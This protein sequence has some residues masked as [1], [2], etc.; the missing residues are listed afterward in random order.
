MLLIAGDADRPAGPYPD[1]L[2][3]L[4]SGL[5]SD[6]EFRHLGFAGHPEGHRAADSDALGRA[7]ETKLIYGRDTGSE[8]WLVSQFTF[9]AEPVIDWLTAL[10][11]TGYRVPVRIG[12]AGPTGFKTLLRYALRCGVASSAR[13]VGQRPGDALKLL[14]QWSPAEM[15]NNLAAAGPLPA[16]G[17]H[18]FPFGGVERAIDWFNGQLLS[19]DR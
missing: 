14:G 16:S 13:F 8:L 9:S 19:S 10:R 2:A 7:L 18:V 15:L 11:T 4:D 17:I 5:L 3:L 6:Y 1:T 12:V